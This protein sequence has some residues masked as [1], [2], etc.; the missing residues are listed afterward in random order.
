VIK[1]N[2]LTSVQ[3]CNIMQVVPAEAVETTAEAV[4]T[5]DGNPVPS[6]SDSKVYIFFYICTGLP[7][8]DITSMQKKIHLPFTPPPPPFFQRR[9]L[10]DHKL[11]PHSDKFGNFLYL[12]PLLHCV[13][14]YS[15]QQATTILTFIK[16]RKRTQPL[17]D[18]I[19]NFK[20]HLYYTF[21]GFS[22]RFARVCKMCYN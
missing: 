21:L 12:H 22:R 19:L 3:V 13:N 2:D 15:V 11:Q 16:K 14:K 10:I 9:Q 1:I 8:T 20:T 5:T 18:A 17:I 7:N 4:E 6:T